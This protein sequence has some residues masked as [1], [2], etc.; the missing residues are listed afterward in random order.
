[1]GELSLKRNIDMTIANTLTTN[2]RGFI[3]T[4]TYYRYGLSPYPFFYTDGI[5]YL[6]NEAQA[7]WLIDTI[8]SVQLLDEVRREDFQLVTLKVN[9][10]ESKA[11]LTIDDGNENVLY[12]QDILYTDFPLS[13]IK[14]Y[15]SRGMVPGFNYKRYGLPQ[16]LMVPSEY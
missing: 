11:I 4:E 12:A 6:A 5:N 1:M 16:V 9:L 14:L 8:V 3:G 7:F 2:L 15:V 13:S 10:E